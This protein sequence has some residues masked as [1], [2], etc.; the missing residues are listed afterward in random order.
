MATTT[1]ANTVQAL[2]TTNNKTATVTLV[3]TYKYTMDVGTFNFTCT[4]ALTDNT[5]TANEYALI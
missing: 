5:W 4:L 1:M 2:P 3:K